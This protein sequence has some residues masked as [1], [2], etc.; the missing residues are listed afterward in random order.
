MSHALRLEEVFAVIGGLT[1]IAMVALA[2][3]ALRTRP[4]ALVNRFLAALLL[5]LS[6]GLVVSALDPFFVEVED[7]SD[8]DVAAIR[9]DPD[10][11]V[12][13]IGWPEALHGALEDLHVDFVFPIMGLLYVMFV[14]HA[15]PMRATAPLR[16]RRAY[17]W[18]AG[19]VA[20][21]WLL[22]PLADGDAGSVARR[23]A[24]ALLIAGAIFGFLTAW[25]HRQRVIG[26]ARRK[27]N[28]YFLAFGA[29]DVG[30]IVGSTCYLVEDMTGTG[31]P[32]ALAYALGDAF[33]HTGMLWFVV[34]LAAGIIR[35]QVLDFDVKVR[36]GMGR[37]AVLAAML[38]A[39]F[40][41]SE[42]VQDLISARMGTL[43]GL[44]CA[45]AMGF[46]AKPLKRFG[47]RLA[48]LS[49]GDAPPLGARSADV[50][51]RL[52]MEQLELMLED[53]PLTPKEVK[54]LEHIRGRLGLSQLR[55]QQLAKSIGAMHLQTPP[56]SKIHG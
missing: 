1:A 9:A 50:H 46:F 10:M 35:S 8:E 24:E 34:F 51:E 3:F 4:H 16:T 49:V 25:H 26:A 42:L 23:I 43:A 54:L 28:A 2:V 52:F 38:G 21:V 53:G 5:G 20:A 41:A 12:H 36:E 37:A 15:L 17:R 44:A 47:Q 32:R 48:A 31:D 45:A 19:I 7:L 55:A 27:A 18:G 30:L 14:A 22:S 6:V 40:V 11:G 56:K 29:L 39:F 33:V 13:T